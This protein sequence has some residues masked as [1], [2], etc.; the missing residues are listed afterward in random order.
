M[1]NDE[2][3]V[4]QTYILIFFLKIFLTMWTSPSIILRF[5]SYIPRDEGLKERVLKESDLPTAKN[6]LQELTTFFERQI[7]AA[8]A[9]SDVWCGKHAFLI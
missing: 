7:A 3:E 4:E 9:E 5:R 2:M 1:A 6:V 8:E